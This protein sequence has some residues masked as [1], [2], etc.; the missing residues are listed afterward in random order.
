MQINVNYLENLRLE[1][2]FDDF[3]VVTDQPIRY[4][5]DGSAPGPFDYFL[6]SSALCAAYFVKVYCKAR[7]IPTTDIRVS[8]N[9]VVDP[10]NRYKQTL[11]ITLELPDWV[12]DK[13]KA[14]ML[15]SIERC[16]VK[17]TIQNA[18]EFIIDAKTSMAEFS[19]SSLDSF[20]NLESETQIVGK[21]ASLEQ[22]IQKMIMLLDSMHIQIE[23]SSWR[24]PVPNVWSVHIRDADS[25]MCYTNGKG[26]TK[27]AALAS[28]LGEYLERLSC[29]Y[30]YA[31]FYLG[32]EIST[33]AFVHYP[34]E[35]WFSLSDTG[36]N[37]EL[38][39]EYC[40][41]IYNQDG[42]LQDRH[43]LDTNSGRK[44]KICALPFIKQSDFSTVYFPNNLIGNLFVSN[45]M[46]AGNSKYEA[47]V[48]ALSEIFE[49]A[50]KNK[51]I[52]E[53]L[54]LPN[55]PGD[56]LEKF[57]EILMG[58]RDLENRGFPI[59]IKDASLNGR[60]PVLCITL[61]NPQT[62]GVFASFGAH[63]RFEIALERCLTELL[64]GRSFE[65]LND[66]PAPSF[67]SLA[68][69]DYNNM[70]DHFVD[71]TGV[72]SWKFFNAQSDY[73]FCFWDFSGDTEE[74]FHHL[75]GIFKQI[76][77]EVY[78]ADYTDL[79]F[80]ACRILVPGFSE[81]YETS[82]LI[83]DNNNQALDFREEIIHLHELSDDDLATLLDKL[84]ASEKD[85]YM[86][87]SEL[88]GIAF[89]ENDDWGQL[90]IGEL[91]CLILLA[92]ERIDE[93]KVYTEMFSAF[94]DGLPA[95][96]R[97]YQL[98]HT[99]IPVIDELPNYV[100]NFTH[101]YGQE[102]VQTVARIIK[103]EERFYRLSPIGKSFQQQPKHQ[104]LIESY[105]KIHAM[106]SQAWKK[107][108]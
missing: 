76:E 57:P 29:N 24:N 99:V 93:A 1:A 35:K 6:A 13:D 97:F 58:I 100:D 104:K 107:T 43:L 14:G 52:T 53:E 27:N 95:R 38:M 101:I 64:Q 18:P 83:W 46:S 50:V 68:V 80:N 92:L 20:R 4:K 21:D 34:D 60:F 48:Q 63:P 47:R 26:Q 11:K 105:K 69:K 65:G 87:I 9:N 62:G 22:S 74:E 72:V 23:I 25:P 91:K 56:V 3:R 73:E 49:R 19:N 88:V 59:L 16:S 89:D 15:A 42:E 55:V 90:V 71:S 102:L 82:D 36:L 79:G 8:Q 2:L 54:A 103:G 61:M 44:D 77:K 17:R 33:E 51:I 98:L 70:I 39:D 45:G 41:H 37:H 67:N 75:M 31:D 81:I 108:P 78:I 106:R 94:Y 66:V 10:H 30:F 84:E 32:Q 5:G 86:P 7:E 96:K 40:H 28:A 85:D 12:S